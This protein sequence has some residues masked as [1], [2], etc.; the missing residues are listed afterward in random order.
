MMIEAVDFNFNGGHFIDNPIPT[1]PLSTATNSYYDGGVSGTNA[2]VVNVDYYGFSDGG[3]EA[4]PY[5]PLDTDVG[6]EITADFL[7][8]KFI[9]TG[10]ADYDM[11]YW[12]G[13]FWENYTRTFP[14]STYNVYGRLAGGAGP[15]DNTTM[16]LV[17]SGA[18]T[19]NQTT[20][21]L[22]SFADANAAGWETW[23]WV[24]MRDT[25]GVLAKAS[26]GG[27]KTLKVTSGNNLNA[28]FFMFVPV[29][30]SQS[31]NLT[32]SISGTSIRIGFQTQ[33]GSTYTVLYND[34]LTGG[35]WQPLSTAVSGDGT[36][37][38]VSDVVGPTQRFYELLIQ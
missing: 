11:G 7:R 15:F 8:E 38:T 20:Q 25:N 17:T 29:I 32:A 6:Q 19:S 37:H 22:G 9:A 36:V 31:V 28:H 27:V 2:A 5:R 34:S 21:L 18:G 14:A 13:G 3:G 33:T 23:H 16:A 12:N 30:T 24:P 35:S 26:L 4:W 10:A 1:A